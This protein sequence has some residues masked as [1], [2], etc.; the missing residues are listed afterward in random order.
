MDWKDI[1][2]KWNSINRTVEDISSKIFNAVEGAVETFNYQE[3]I[4]DPTLDTAD[5]AE[6]AVRTRLPFSDLIIDFPTTQAMGRSTRMAFPAYIQTFSDNFTPNFSGVEVFGRSDP[7][8]VYKSTT[9]SVS[10][11]VMI[12][13]FDAAD[14]NEN[15]KKI[16]KVIKNLYP[17]YERLSTGALVLDSPPLVRIKFAN[18]ITN[19]V[20]PNKGLLGYINAFQSDFGIRERGVF[21][22]FEKIFPKA[23][24]LAITFTPLHEHT[25]GF[26]STFSTG[27]FL[28]DENYPYDV[29]STR[30]E[31]KMDSN[32]GLGAEVTEDDILGG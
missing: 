5:P 13:C 10:I 31:L 22:G 25:V 11:G 6:I 30:K 20:N 4:V 23:I 28:G 3:D 21:L 9:R 15:L 32:V 2:K 7:I 29:V 8:P 19:H 1:N 16:N 12:P 27:K 26:D 24:G 18:L 14:S 17:G